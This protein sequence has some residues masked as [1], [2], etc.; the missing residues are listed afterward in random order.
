[1][2]TL[3]LGGGALNFLLLCACREEST[4]EGVVQEGGRP[5]LPGTVYVCVSS[6]KFHR[7]ETTPPLLKCPPLAPEKGWGWPRFPGLWA[8]AERLGLKSIS[9]LTGL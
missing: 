8:A 6:R 7:P 2:A 5:P 4:Q 9:A 1:M 3:S